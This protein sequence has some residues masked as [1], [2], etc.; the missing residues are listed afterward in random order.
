[1]LDRLPLALRLLAREWRAGEVRVLLLAVSLAVASLTAVAFFTDRV[2]GALERE[3]NT[4]LAADLSL[5]SDHPIGPEVAAEARQRGLAVLGTTTF[6]SMA[7]AGDQ[8][9]LSGIKAVEPGYPL[10]GSLRVASALFGPDGP[11]RRLPGPGE[12]WVDERLASGLGLDVGG[13]V[14]VGAV[15][16]RV[17]AI[18]TFEGER[19]G[20]FMALAPRVMLSPEDLARSGLVQE[21]SRITW[22]LLVAGEPGAVDAFRGWLTRRL[23]RGQ[24]LEGVRDARPELRE[25]L[26]QARR[27]L[28]LASVLAVVLA[29]AAAHLA[30]RRYA[31]RHYDG[32]ALMRCFGAPRRRLISLHFQQMAL[33]GLAAGLLGSGLGWLTQEALAALLGD[34]LH[35]G[36][37]AP[38]VWP[39][40]LGLGSGLALVLAF[41]LPP[42]LRLG[43]VPVARV[44]RKDLGPPGGGAWLAHGAGLALVAGLIFQQAGEPKLGA[45]VLGGVVAAMAAAGLLARGLL[46]P[47]AAAARAL[48][49]TTT[50]W[51]LGLRLGLG[52]LGRRG[53]ETTLQA[54][55][56]SLGLLALLVLTLT[57]DDLLDNWKSQV[58]VG[59][60]N[61]FLINIQPEQV[62]PLKDYLDRGGV[63]QAELYPMARGRLMAIAGRPV[64]PADYPEGRARRLAERE[65][66]LSALAAL[67]PDNQLLAGRWWRPGETSGFSVEEG[68]AKTLG[69]RLGDTLEFDAGG[70]PL[71]GTVLSLRKVNWDS[72]R[73]N[74][75]VVGP[76]GTLDGVPL[77]HI[78]AFH[79]PRDQAGLLHG[80]VA[81]FPNVPV[82][83]VE[84]A[85]AQVRDLL[86]RVG[87]GVRLIFLFSLGTGLTVMLAAL[88]ARR[89]ER[90]REIGL[91]RTLGASR[92]TVRWALAT[93]FACL[94][95]LAGA[96][97]AAAASG[98][99]WL[100]A[101]RAFNLPH[102]PDPLI[103][104]AG[105]GGGLVLVASA[106]LLSTR[107]LLQ[108]PA[109]RVVRQG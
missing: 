45:M 66:N 62:A 27:Y 51:R 15:T 69:I 99:G 89:D 24:L 30:L 80:L 38:T 61:R 47:L 103:W 84:Q 88:Y 34:A 52:S 19:G 22:R 83:D 1:M 21:G 17:G 42:L 9:L 28:G 64:S 92:A 33:L 55:A 43:R 101:T 63:A 41:S 67:P 40:L 36:L 78:T 50:P 37:P 100:L 18:L 35:L 54:M 7:M 86:D 53:S 79:L 105:L 4:L 81:A 5:S 39:L 108:E 107:P 16:L 94:G 20:N 31:T 71:Q 85:M 13:R 95:L 75:F 25:V 49:A 82:I 70:L 76:P 56:L 68:L 2:A 26:D 93:E 77:S 3:A 65:F 73:V 11:T 102:Q 87:D 8:P 90:A 74:F 14:K 97:A 98:L 91:W 29:A 106:G 57:R 109:W 6:L 44:L 12:A 72:F 46:A 104:L 60:P 48:P 59:A 10:R 58:P 32:F 23:E 96:V